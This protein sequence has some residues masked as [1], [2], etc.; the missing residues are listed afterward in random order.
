MKFKKT[1]AIIIVAILTLTCFVAC[2][3]K[4]TEEEVGTTVPVEEGTT[5]EEVPETVNV[6]VLKGPTGMQTAYLMHIVNSGEYEGSNAY[7]FDVETAADVV[8]SMLLSGEVDIAAIPSNAAATLYKKTEGK[9][10]IIATNTLNVLTLMSS[11][12]SVTSFED[13]EGRTI[14]ASGEGTSAQYVLET[15]LGENGLVDGENITIQ[16]TAEHA[17]S[18]TLAKSGDTDIV[19][20]PEPFATQLLLADAGFDYAIDFN[21]EISRLGLN[22][23]MGVYAV[24]TDFLEKYP[25]AV[26]EFLEDMLASHTFLTSAGDTAAEYV[27]EADIMT[28]AVAV[29]AIPNIYFRFTTGQEAADLCDGMFEMLYERNPQSVGGEIPSDDIYYK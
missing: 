27:E 12:S 24:R 29:K 10:K 18:V 5:A 26:D 3:K 11:D 21:S 28:F 19:V 8:N 14:T 25:S 15:I 6:A 23:V 16:Y 1:I 4:E 9:V 22:I 2:G 13:L 20:L 7:S 17:E